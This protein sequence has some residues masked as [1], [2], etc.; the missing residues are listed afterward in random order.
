MDNVDTSTDEISL[1]DLWNTLYKRRNTVFLVFILVLLISVAVI[2]LMKPIYESRAVLSIGKVGALENKDQR[3]SFV[4]EPVDELV[5]R[6]QEL[7]KVNDASEANK[8]PPFVHSIK[9]NK[10]QGENIVEFTARDFSAKGAQAYLNIVVQKLLSEHQ[11]IYLKALGSRQKSL[12]ALI[13]YKSN[14]QAK[15]QGMSKLLRKLNQQNPVPAALLTIEEGKYFSMLPELESA[16]SDTRMSMSELQTKPT[17]LLREPT[18][19]RQSVYPRPFL[20]L[21]L[22]LFIGLFTGVIAAFIHDFFANI[23]N[24]ES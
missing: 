9:V 18:L 17:T 5:R 24:P 2:L 20:Y 22:G 3:N 4:I 16:I 10:K 15:L 1:Y 21:T 13:E 23:R 7:Y 6:L 8:A 14:I 11:Q 19:A 12:D